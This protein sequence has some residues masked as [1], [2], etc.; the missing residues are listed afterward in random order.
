MKRLLK[1][2]RRLRDECGIGNITF[3]TVIKRGKGFGGTQQEFATLMRRFNRILT[4]K[5]CREPKMRVHKVMGFSA[6]ADGTEMDPSE[7]AQDTLHPTRD[8]D[9]EVFDRY[10]RELRAALYH[11]VGAYEDDRIIYGECDRVVC[12]GE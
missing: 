10:M 3:L 6:H 12:A 1:R 4:D 8:W 5:V 2:A 9:S 7:W 11:A